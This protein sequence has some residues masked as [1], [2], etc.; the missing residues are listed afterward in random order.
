V[1]VDATPPLSG[2]DTT[3]SQR[4][5]AFTIGCVVLAVLLV[6]ALRG[7]VAT[8][9][10]GPIVRLSIAVAGAGFAGFLF[11]YFDWNLPGQ[12]KAG[13]TLGVFLFLLLWNPGSAAIPYLNKNFDSCKDNVLAGH[14]DIALA[15]CQQA[16]N[17]LADYYDPVF[18]LAQAQ[19]GQGSYN[20]AIT[21]FERALKLGAD[22]ARSYYGV[23]LANSK[24]DKFDQAI[25]A[26][27]RALD[28]YVGNKEFQARLDYLIADAEKS[29][30]NF[31]QGAEP[32]FVNARDF[33]K[34]F[35]KDGYP[36]YKAQAEL[37][38]ILAVKAETLP[39]GEDKSALETDALDAFTKALESIRAYSSGSDPDAEKSAFV[40]AYAMDSGRCGT[41]LSQLWAARK[42]SNYAH[43]LN[44]VLGVS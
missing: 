17:E 44:A 26:A 39:E 12:F 4:T 34:A 40:R 32:H 30:W 10:V 5:V 29:L 28:A 37:A 22:P 1:S 9:L 21:S 25:E 38:C 11:G 43:E 41:A 7:W 8:D 14:S 33:F 19:F 6:V 20:A 24:L 3:K 15:F 27:E 2:S 23:A 18:W 31:G 16:A 35:L 42:S 36:T 13:G